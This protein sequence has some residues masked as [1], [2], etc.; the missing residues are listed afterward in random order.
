MLF[1]TQIY[2]IRPFKGSLIFLALARVTGSPWI[3]LIIVFILL[4]VVTIFVFLGINLRFLVTSFR[5][6][7]G[8]SQI[9]ALARLNFF[10]VLNFDLAHNFGG[11]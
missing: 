11:F 5:F 6:G 3:S 9:V 7:N 8:S 2:S 10:I 4:L 1:S